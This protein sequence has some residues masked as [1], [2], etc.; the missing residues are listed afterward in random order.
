MCHILLQALRDR[1]LHLKNIFDEN[2]TQQMDD[3]RKLDVSYLTDNYKRPIIETPE[4]FPPF[5]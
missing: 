1:L 4:I 2:L 3:Q 5:C